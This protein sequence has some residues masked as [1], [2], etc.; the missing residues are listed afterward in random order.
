MIFLES[1]NTPSNTKRYSSSSEYATPGGVDESENSLYF[2]FCDNPTEREKEN[3]TQEDQWAITDLAPSPS[4]SSHVFRAKTPLL[5]KVLQSNFTP[6]N[7]N[8]KRVSFSHVPKG[9]P[10]A[11][12]AD[13]ILKSDSNGL[14]MEFNRNTMFDLD[15]IK[16]SL[17]CTTIA[18]DYKLF[19]K[20]ETEQD[21]IDTSNTTDD[22][23]DEMHDDTMIENPS[24]STH[25]NASLSKKTNE[26]SAPNA[27]S[28]DGLKKP[29]KKNDMVEMDSALLQES[30]G[31]NSKMVV[32]KLLSGA[33]IKPQ[34]TR[35]TIK[36]DRRR[37]GKDNRKTMNPTRSTTYKRR[38]ST[39]EPRKVDPRKS[40]GVLRNVASKL[41]KSIPGK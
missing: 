11:G 8:N 23:D 22:F 12:H 5:R 24:T 6:R 19:V 36:I 37:L 33:S 38:S 13:K 9:S 28:L 15:P 16:E 3:A 29:I 30:D 31:V 2:S 18:K 14:Q 27:S 4:T 1:M 20:N 40:L 17:P 7:G 32:K 39:Y 25:N 26:N 10:I 41:S 35:N 34:Q 21:P